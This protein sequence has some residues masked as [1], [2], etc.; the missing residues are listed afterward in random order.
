MYVVYVHTPTQHPCRWGELEY[1]NLSL[2][3]ADL[4][5]AVKSATTSVAERAH[6][7]A[8]ELADKRKHLWGLIDEIRISAAPV[9]ATLLCVFCVCSVCGVVWAWC[10]VSMCECLCV[11][12]GVG[13]VWC[14]VC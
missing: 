1:V 5:A 9:R 10:V 12:C 3:P 4:A 11:W 8:A 7:T 13:L 6:R 2:A 14:C